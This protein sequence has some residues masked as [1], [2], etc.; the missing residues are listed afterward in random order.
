[1]QGV[2]FLRNIAQQGESDL[3]QTIQIFTEQAAPVQCSEQHFSPTLPSL[4][5]GEES[6]TSE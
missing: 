6:S 2:G 1:M 5:L 4:G 3:Q